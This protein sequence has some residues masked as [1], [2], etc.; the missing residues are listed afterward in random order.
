MKLTPNQ[1][2]KSLSKT[3]LDFSCIFRSQ[4]NGAIDTVIDL[5]SQAG[6]KNLSVLKKACKALKIPTRKCWKSL[7][8]FWTTI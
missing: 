2:V 8:L 4:S 3:K 1:I 5:F 7:T 6:M